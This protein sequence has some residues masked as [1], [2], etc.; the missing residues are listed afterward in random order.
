MMSVSD[1]IGNGA[2]D[3]VFFFGRQYFGMPIKLNTKS[4]KKVLE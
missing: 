1:E 4:T 3:E 2:V